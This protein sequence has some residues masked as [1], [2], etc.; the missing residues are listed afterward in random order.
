MKK[1]AFELIDLGRATE[2]TKGV[3]NAVFTEV[4]IPPTN[5]T[6]IHR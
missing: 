3:A 2:R 4:G 1:R 6:W 5:R